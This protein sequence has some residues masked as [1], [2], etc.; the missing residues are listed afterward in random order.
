[1]PEIDT[2]ATSL[3]EEAKRFLEIA[4]RAK[5]APATT[6]NLHA[7]L[8]LGFCSLEAHINGIA[9]D[10]S[11]RKDI[12]LLEKSVLQ[13]REV[14]F[15][16]G[17]F[18][19]KGTRYYSIAERIKLMHRYFDSKPLDTSQVWWSRL[20]DAIIL[21]NQLTHP[22]DPPPK[23]TSQAVQAALESIVAA[24]DSLFRAVYKK[25]FPAAGRG[26]ESRLEF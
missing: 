17:Q 1:V 12:P 22:R 5:S 11:H 26:L 23:I 15:D 10:F 7:A 24:I 2:L 16:G 18:A 6:A 3:L 13:E 9:A 8:M 14:K 20:S 19:L 4:K 25:P 21:R